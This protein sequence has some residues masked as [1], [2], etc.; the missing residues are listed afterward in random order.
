[1]GMLGLNRDILVGMGASISASSAAAH[2]L[3]GG[4]P[5]RAASLISAVDYGTFLSVFAAAFYISN[6][7]RYAG[8]G[9]RDLRRDLWRLAVSMGSAELVYIACRWS[10]LYLLLGTG[11]DPL[12]AS[13]ASQAA[14]T[15]AYLAALNLGARL[16]GLFR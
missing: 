8:A 5:G 14:S 3:G 4:D 7:R 12:A 1:M 2:Y 6:R 9:R 10:S 11:G 15:A 13:L 16:V